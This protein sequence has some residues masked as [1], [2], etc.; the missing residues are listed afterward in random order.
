MSVAAVKWAID[1]KVGD[2]TA[3]SVLVIL[4]WHHNPENGLCLSLIHI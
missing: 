2:V 3:K 4:A 1:Q